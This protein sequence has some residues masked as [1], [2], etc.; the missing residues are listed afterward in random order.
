MTELQ[1]LDSALD[2]NAADL[3]ANRAGQLSPRQIERLRKT[4][5]RNLSIGAALVLAL[6]VVSSGFL[7]FGAAQKSLILSL[8]G[9]GVTLCNAALLGVSVR[10]ALRLSSDIDK[11]AVQTLAGPIKHTIRVTGRVATYIIHSSGQEIVVSKPTFFALKE[12]AAYR[13]YRT[14][15]ASVLLSAELAPSPPA[16]L[17]VGEK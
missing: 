3:D 16:P 2:F 4:R 10:A 5:R 6:I 13:L 9:I 11:R 8:V 15:E 7:Y 12:N 17:P 1:S 14:P